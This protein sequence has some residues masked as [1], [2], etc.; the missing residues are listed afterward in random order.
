[1]GERVPQWI[2]GERVG[3]FFDLHGCLIPTKRKAI[4]AMGDSTTMGDRAMGDSAGSK[5]DRA[6]GDSAGSKG[7]RAMGESAGSKGDHASIPS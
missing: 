3:E 2:V 7:D 1:M 4:D 5:G 6:L